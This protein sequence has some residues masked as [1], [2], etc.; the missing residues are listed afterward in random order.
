MM[1]LGFVSAILPELSFQEVISLAEE[2]GYS[3]VE[4]MCWPHGKAERRYAGVTHVDVDDL[5]AQDISRMRKVLK[6]KEIVISGLGYYPNA[7]DPDE[8]AAAY[9]REHLKKVIAAAARLDV[10]VVNT[11]IGR[12]P[13]KTLEENFKK[14]AVVWP[15]I[16]SFA[17]GQKVKIAIENCPM[18]FTTDEWPGGKNLAVSPAVWRR[19]F[20]EIPSKSFGLNLD[21]SHLLWQ[22]MDYVKPIYEFAERIF[23]VHIKD[24]KVRRDRLDDVGI[25]ATPLEFHSPV[26]PGLGEMRWGR[27]VSA[28]LD[29]GYDGCACI[30]VEDRSFEKDLDSRVAALGM[31]GHYMR[32]FIAG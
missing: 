13:S 12:D 32:Q 2:E 16:V 26:L 11:F 1:K 24:A 3:C 21:P 14:F 7:L 15:E 18:L 5:S 17:E 8:K 25:L 19:M 28:L 27:F 10:G 6:E 4:L 20:S 30:E 22:Q 9:C 31:S 23:H 29:V